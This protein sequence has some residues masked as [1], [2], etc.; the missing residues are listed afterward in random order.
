MNLPTCNFIQVH[1]LPPPTSKCS[2]QNVVPKHN[3]FMF[4]FPEEDHV[5]H[6]YS[7]LSHSS[8]PVLGG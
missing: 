3:Q 5:S 1:L 2:P 4:F 6:P 7:R 8:V